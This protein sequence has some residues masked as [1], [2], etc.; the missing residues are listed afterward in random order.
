[1]LQPEFAGHVVFLEDYDIQLARWLV[2]GVDVWLNNPIAPLEASGTSGIKA[3]ING[4]LNLSVLDGWWAEAFDGSNGWGIPGSDAQDTARRDALDS[5]AILDCL[6]EDVMPLYYTHDG[7]GYSSE[8]VRR[9]K[10]AMATVLPRFSMRRTVRDYVAGMYRPAA[11]HGAGLT[12]DAA[13]AA[14]RLADWKQRVRAAWGD[15]RL[16]G[17]D[18][19]P[20]AGG[21][22]APLAMRVRVS[23]GGLDPADVRVEFRRAA[24]CQRRSSSRRRC[25]P[26][27]MGCRPD[28]GARSSRR[29]V[30]AMRMATPSTR[31]PRDRRPPASTRAR[32]GSIPGMNCWGTRSRWG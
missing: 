25:V 3:A 27:G 28:N 16:V 30:S 20:T 9:C 1:M 11:A 6:E 29:P 31:S 15:V 2:T 13:L 19:M 8:W 10:R 4:R 23:L 5:D 7:R 14:R 26:S 24:A 32:C 12:A 22:G 21:T 18:E 17:M